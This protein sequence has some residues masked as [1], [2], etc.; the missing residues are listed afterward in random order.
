MNV[1]RAE[2]GDLVWSRDLLRDYEIRMPDWGIT[3]APLVFGDLVIQI[4]AG[5]D[6]ACVVA[7]ELATGKER[8]R[9][10]DEPAGYSA[11]IMIRQGESDVLVCWTGESVSGLD[12]LT[13]TRHWSV[14]MKPRKMPIGVPTPVVEG[15]RLFVSSFYD[16]SMLIQLDQDKPAAKR[17]WHRVG[18]SERNT[19]ALHA[20]ISGPIIKG[21]LI[22]GADSYG[23][24]RCLDLETGDRI[25]EDLTV[26][27]TARW[28]TVHT[29]QNG[30]DE[31]MLNDQ[32]ELLFTTLSRDGVRIRSRS[33]LIDPTLHQLR[34]RAGVIWSAPAI[35]D[36]MIY[37][38]SDDQLICAS[39]RRDAGSKQDD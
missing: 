27:P 22:Y 26:V 33:L 19:D 7:F 17:L 24:F 20:M 35:A 10:I 38:R 12:P 13:G 31:I 21:G 14:E 5:K 28:A 25:W 18:Q 11:P 9:A 32:G 36:G 2:T 3:A 29:I 15:D 23:E 16:G 37:A 8:W 1:L 39:L 30:D 4:V 6:D 34:R